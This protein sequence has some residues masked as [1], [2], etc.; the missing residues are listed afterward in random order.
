MSEK[1]RELSFNLFLTP[2]ARSKNAVIEKNL[3][4][5]VCYFKKLLTRKKDCDIMNGRVK[6][7]KLRGVAL[8]GDVSERTLRVSKR[9]IRSGSN[10]AI[11]EQATP[12]DDRA[13][14]APGS[15]ACARL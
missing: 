1:S 13:L 5:S 6:I 3:A 10:L 11:G 4:K 14:V 12:C 15:D 9:G 2:C 7:Q 8:S